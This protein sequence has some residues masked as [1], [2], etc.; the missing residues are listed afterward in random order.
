MK[1]I[2][3]DEPFEFGVATASYQ[4]EGAWNEGGKGESNWDRFTH[5]P[6]NIVDGT[7]ADVACDFYHRYKEDIQLA[8][9]LGFRVFRLSVSWSRIFPAGVGEINQ[10]GIDFY[11]NVLETIKGH[12]MKVSLTIFHW[13]L[14]QRLQD[15]G[16]WGN[17]DIVGWYTEYA[18]VLFRE[19]GDL[20]DYWIT[21]NEPINPSILGYW[22]GEHA[23]GYHDYSLALTAVHHLLLS[24]GSAVREF[25]KLG[26]T[27]E[28]GITLNMNYAYP[29]D[30][31]NAA[32]VAAARRMMDQNNSLFGDPVWNGEYP[33][34]LFSYLSKQGVVLPEIREGDMELIHQPLDFF[35]LNNYFA[36]V[37]RA[38][39][40]EWPLCARTVKCG[41]PQ[42]DAN[43]E[44][45]PDG[46][47]DLLI[48]IN[49]RYAP[50]KL[51]ITENGTANNDWVDVN[52]RVE[53]PKRIDFFKQYLAEV[54][55]AMDDGVPVTAYYVWSFYDNFEWAWG[56]QR[57]FGIVYVNYQTQERIV[58]KSGYWFSELIQNRGYDFWE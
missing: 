5:T 30:P 21:L 31:D 53:D 44:V 26:L 9:D 56:L 6:G 23:P 3:F 37:V 51:I 29:A 50:P 38:D 13:D 48:W 24:H 55:H 35:G 11:R 19:Y 45:W 57:R 8:A 52:G 22:T 46:L 54:R 16:G 39:T 7:N 27:S 15:R 2:T 41:R 43:W 18:K 28:I 47:Y 32:D 42:T 17:R 1:R 14:P 10:E 4:I 12:G 49:R 25:R 40:N 58:K 34:E 36:D 20:V 33:A